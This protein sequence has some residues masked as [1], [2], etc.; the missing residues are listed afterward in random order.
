[1]QQVLDQ[2]IAS[3]A[4]QP[5]VA[6]FVDSRNP[7]KLRE[8]RRNS[9]FMCNKLYAMFFANELVPA[10]QSKF[11]I[12]PLPSDRVILGLSFGGL[13]AGCFGLM[14]PH[15]FPNIAM[16]SPASGK[17]VKVLSEQ[18]NNLDKLPLKIFF[19]HGTRKDNTKSSRKFHEVLEQKGYDMTYIQ[20]AQSHNWDNWQP[21]LD[22]VLVT[23]FSKT[24]P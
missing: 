8:N 14:L 21:L 11:P 2:E 12:S 18:F 7:N 20:V 22:D 17:H 6:V 13:N 24:P 19:S 23:F 15:F 5:V 4:I 3:G 16:Q 9:Q 1:M 10:I